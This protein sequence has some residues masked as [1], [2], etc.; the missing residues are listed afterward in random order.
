MWNTKKYSA[1]VVLGVGLVVAAATPALSQGGQGWRGPY[2][3]AG[4]VGHAY[5]GYGSY[6]LPGYGGPGYGTYTQIAAA[7]GYGYG[8]LYGL[9]Y[10]LRRPAW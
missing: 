6:A 5:S 7:R 2:G 10:A 8:G 3:Q 4:Y 9:G 1:M